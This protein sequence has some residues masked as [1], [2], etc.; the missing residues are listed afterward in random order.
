L[1]TRRE[2]GKKKGAR[3]R[4]GKEGAASC[5]AD[6]ALGVLLVGQGSRRWRWGCPGT[7]TQ[8]IGCLNEED[9]ILFP[10]SPLAL[11]SFLG[12]LKTALVC[13]V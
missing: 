11:G 8:V 12:K 2:T 4:E 9:N 10:K 5:R 7:A 3:E 13:I 1:A 6:G